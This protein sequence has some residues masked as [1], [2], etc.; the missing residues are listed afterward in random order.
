M[1]TETTFKGYE[2]T[3]IYLIEEMTNILNYGYNNSNKSLIEL[4]KELKL[5]YGIEV[6]TYFLKNLISNR[7]NTK[8]L[9]RLNYILK[10]ED[11]KTTDINKYL[12][13]SWI[14]KKVNVDITYFNEK[15]AENIVIFETKNKTIDKSYISNYK[16]LFKQIVLN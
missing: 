2:N 16:K 3:Y 10:K 8:K 6:T 1:I 7:T 4:L 15:E 5:N 13:R 11:I 9:N 14:F 12:L